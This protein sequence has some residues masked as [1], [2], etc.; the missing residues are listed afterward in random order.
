MEFKKKSEG[1]Y[2]AK[3]GPLEVSVFAGLDDWDLLVQCELRIGPHKWLVQ[4]RLGTDYPTPEAAM[5]AAP[6]LIIPLLEEVSSVLRAARSAK[7]SSQ[8]LSA[9]S[10]VAG[11]D[12]V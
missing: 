5:A 11:E 7:E 2:V 8:S 12:M 3:K 10:R 9:L 1:S 4:M 6:A